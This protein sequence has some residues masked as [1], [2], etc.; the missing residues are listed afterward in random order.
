MP[1]ERLVVFKFSY[2][3]LS[4]HSSTVVVDIVMIRCSQISY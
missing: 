1:L 2:V 3:F 4:S